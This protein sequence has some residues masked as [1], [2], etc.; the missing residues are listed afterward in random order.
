MI[1]EFIWSGFVARV[2]VIITV[3]F[4]RAF[5]VMIDLSSPCAT[6]PTYQHALLTATSAPAVS[7]LVPR[8]GQHIQRSIGELGGLEARN[9]F[10]DVL[11][12]GAVVALEGTIW[13]N[14]LVRADSDC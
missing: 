4:I 2:Y 7:P 10:G 11:D 14:V 1:I 5:V 3:R 13:V 9:F 6:P 12:V 8:I